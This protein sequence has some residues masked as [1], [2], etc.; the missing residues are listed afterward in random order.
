VATAPIRPLAWESPYAVE[1]ALEKAKRQKR[2]ERKIGKEKKKKERD[3]QSRY[4]ITKLTK[5]KNKEKILKAGKG[6]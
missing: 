1:A 2:K 4:S 6:I 3:P 5:T